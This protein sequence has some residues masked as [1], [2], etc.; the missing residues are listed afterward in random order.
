MGHHHHG[1]AIHGQAHHAVQHL[2]DHFRVERG[3]RLVKQHGNR[4]H[5]ERPRNRHALLLAA[6]QLARKLVFVRHQAHAIQVF[7]AVCFGFVGIAT[8]HLDLRDGQVHVDPFTKMRPEVTYRV[9]A[10]TRY[11]VEEMTEACQPAT[12]GRGGQRLA[13]HIADQMTLRK[14]DNVDVV[15]VHDAG[16]RL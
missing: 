5:A 13:Q 7:Q 6:R 2:A 9:R 11:A 14:I 1:H 12:A 3:G 4:V 16:E 15:V 8:Q 10:C